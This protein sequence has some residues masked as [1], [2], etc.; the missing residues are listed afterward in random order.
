M[1]LSFDD[2]GVCYTS[3]EIEAHGMYVSYFFFR[4]VNKLN[5]LRESITERINT[6]RFE[7]RGSFSYE[8]RGMY[9]CLLLFL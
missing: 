2:A 6:V 1:E 8:A 9:V 5:V 7:A 3:D 4:N